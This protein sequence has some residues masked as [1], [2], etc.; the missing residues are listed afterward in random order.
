[1]IV[2]VCISLILL[3]IIASLIF[4]SYNHKSLRKTLEDGTRKQK[5]KQQ[6]LNLVQLLVMDGEARDLCSLK[7]C[8]SKALTAM[9]TKHAEFK[10]GQGKWIIKE[11]IIAFPFFVPFDV[12]R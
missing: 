4:Q 7:T 12:R 6:H 5:K 8:F 3:D 11:E 1:M 10:E 2:V 9:I